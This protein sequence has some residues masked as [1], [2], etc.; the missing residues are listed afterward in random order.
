MCG[1]THATF[2]YQAAPNRLVRQAGADYDNPR[3]E[4]VLDL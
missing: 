4:A 3:V 2:K 1:H